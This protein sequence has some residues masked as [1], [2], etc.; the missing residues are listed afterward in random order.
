M[1]KF[2]VA[3]Y[4]CMYRDGSLMVGDNCEDWENYLNKVGYKYRGIISI[5]AFGEIF[6]SL[7]SAHPQSKKFWKNFS[8]LYLNFCIFNKKYEFMDGH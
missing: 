4:R 7:I 5:S 3:P 2:A 6:K 8:I 1:T